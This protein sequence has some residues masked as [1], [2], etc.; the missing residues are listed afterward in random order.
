M[1][2]GDNETDT[3]SETQTS[4]SS[5]E[6]ADSTSDT[7]VEQLQKYL[8]EKLGIFTSDEKSTDKTEKV[9]KMKMPYLVLLFSIKLSNMIL[10]IRQIGYWGDCRLY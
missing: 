9:W 1:F 4:S 7:N 10:G 5:S 6:S 2:A 8:A 3:S